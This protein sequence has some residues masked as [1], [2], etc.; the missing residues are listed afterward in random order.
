MKQVE[1]S[2]VLMPVWGVGPLLP[3]QFYKSAGSVLRDCEMRTNRRSSN[4]TEDEII[5]WLDLK[6]CGSVLYMSFGTEMGPTLND[7]STLAN[8]LEASNPPI[9]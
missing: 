6:S 2:M 1:G 7:Y 5:Q 3:E 4:M 8:D 9:I